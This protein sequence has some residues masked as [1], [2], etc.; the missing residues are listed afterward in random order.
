MGEPVYKILTESAFEEA[1][2]AGRFEG[3][4]DDRRDGFIHLS[5]AHQVGATLATHFAGRD[6]LVLLALDSAKLGE[7][8]RWEISRSG[9]PFP[10]LYALLDL[11]HVLSVESLPL[12]DDGRH[13]LPEGVSA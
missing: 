3:S 11:A 12:G 5:A 10:H 6:D 4:S 2:L 7:P 8:L 1:M 13:I 9:A